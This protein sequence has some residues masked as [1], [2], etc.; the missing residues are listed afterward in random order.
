MIAD[1]YF[2]N[3][4]DR[5]KMHNIVPHA[6]NQRHRRQ[7]ITAGMAPGTHA[8]LAKCASL[9]QQ[10]PRIAG[11]II[12][13]Q[14]ANN[15]GYAGSRESTQRYRWNSTGKARF[16]AAPCHVGV[17]VNKARHDAAPAQVIARDSCQAKVRFGLADPEDS[18]GADQNVA[19]ADVVRSEDASIL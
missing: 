6:A 17:A 4:N 10:G 18:T 9:C 12:S 2:A 7:V 14:N 8:L 3:T 5:I 1:C 16:S 11:R 15:T 13:T 19:N